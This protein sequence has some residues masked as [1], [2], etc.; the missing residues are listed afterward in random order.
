MHVHGVESMSMK[1]FVRLEYQHLDALTQI[2]RFSTESSTA[3]V[4]FSIQSFLKE[5]SPVVIKTF[6]FDL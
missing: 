5:I 4:N 6:P 3:R 1:F 2:K